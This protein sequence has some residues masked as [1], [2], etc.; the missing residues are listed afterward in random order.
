MRISRSLRLATSVA[1]SAVVIT[2]VGAALTTAPAFAAPRPRV[3]QPVI[4]LTPA[5]SPTTSQTMLATWPTVSGASYTCQLDRAKPAPCNSGTWSST[6]VQ[7]VLADGTHTLTVKATKSGNRPSTA[8]KTWVVDTTKPVPPTL[9]GVTSPTSTTSVHVSWSDLDANGIAGYL[10]ELNGTNLSAATICGNGSAS[11]G[12]GGP[13]GSWQLPIGSAQSGWNTVYVWATDTAGNTSVT[14]TPNS[15]ATGPAAGVT[16]GT[17][18]WKVDNSAP[19][20]PSF[21]QAPPANWNS[22]T[23]HFVWQDSDFDGTNTVSVTNFVCALDGP[24]YTPCNNAGTDVTVTA[25][26]SHS[27]SV[28]GRDD[29]GNVGP[30]ATWNW[31]VDTVAPPTPFINSVPPATSDLSTPS[32][33]FGDDEASVSFRCGFDSADVSTY[34]SCAS[35]FDSSSKFA[36]LNDGPHTFYVVA[37]DAAGNDSAAKTY[38]WTIDTSATT[39]VAVSAPSFTGAPAYWSND[40]NPAFTWVDN[41][42][43]P[44]QDQCKLDSGTWHNCTSGDSFAV[45]T[46]TLHTLSVRSVDA[47]ASATSDA[48]SWS[49]NYDNT[50]P[51]ASLTKTPATISNNP[52]PE[53]DFTSETGARFTCT[54]DTD[55]SSICGSPAIYNGV[56]DGPHTFA[57][58]AADAAGNTSTATYHWS[59][60]TS[61]PPAPTLVAPPAYTN[62]PP[63]SVSWTDSDSSVLPSSTCKLNGA[64]YTPCDA[65]GTVVTTSAD[66]SYTF[67]VTVS[68][69][70]HSSARSVT[71]TQDTQKPD[72]SGI[73]HVPADGSYSS[74]ASVTPDVSGVTDDNLDTVTCSLDGGAPAACGTIS[75]GDGSRTLDIVATDL[76][77]N[78][79][80]YTRTWTVDTVAPVVGVDVSG[81]VS[82]TGYNNTGNVSPAV[83]FDETNPDLVNF[84]PNGY[85][86]S[87]DDG[88]STVA[89]D[90]GPYTNLP[91]GHYTLTVTATD[92]AGLSAGPATANWTVDTTAPATPS[93]TSTDVENGGTINSAPTI[94]VDD[95]SNDVSSYSCTLSSV[96][97]TTTT[98]SVAAGAVEFSGSGL[99]DDSYTVSVT[100]TDAATNVSDTA[101]T[102]SFVIDSNAPA[103]PSVNGTSGVVKSTS[104]AFTLTDDD[105]TATFVCELDAETTFTPCD[106]N[107]S[108]HNLSEGDHTLSVKAV[109]SA[110]NM[111]PTQTVT[112]TVDTTAPQLVV[113]GVPTTLT[114]ATSVTPS[115]TQTGEAHPG[116]LVCGLD[117]AP[118]GC[119]SRFTVGDGSH[120][121]TA[122]TT[123]LAGNAAAQVTRSW[124]VDATAPSAKMTRM[125]SLTGR[126]TATW[127]EPVSGLDT[128]KVT[129]VD[130]NGGAV[131]PTAVS[132]G[133][134]DCS[135]TITSMS[136]APT[137][138]LLP[139]EHYT[140]KIGA[141]AAKD[142]ANNASL[143]SVKSFRALRTLQENTIP[144][145]SG[146][147]R[148]KT[149]AAYGKSYVREH[150]KG[151][152]ANWTFRGSRVTWWTVTGP[153][154]G[155]AAVFIDGHRLKTVN[156]YATATHYRVARTLRH[157]G[158]GTHRLTIRVMG[159]KGAKAGKGTFVA[160]DGFTVGTKRT[161][162]PKLATAWRR[163]AGTRY[164]GSH[165]TTANLAGQTV[166]LRF[167]GTSITWTTVRNRTQGKAR[168]YVDGV[169]KAT[170]DNYSSTARYKVRRVV[171]GLTDAVHTVKI[172][173]L[174][175]HRKASHGN[176]ITVDRLVVG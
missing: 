30:V 126:S 104:A 121:F 37:E 71:W 33:G 72:V 41:E 35:P 89:S 8:S 102:Y 128:S 45:S 118:V 137:K 16:P 165:A 93:L 156:T 80:T 163:V 40:A 1:A 143:V 10:C 5:T 59:I 65:A 51:V 82:S 141:G 116:A 154:Q 7:P 57:V 136:V 95:T 87:L 99:A 91:D 112:W 9:G 108:L 3:T 98:C 2:T 107:L 22:R 70:G 146:W 140:L 11:G 159:L 86:C 49:W 43:D 174:G 96:A 85:A 55:P 36:P 139:G 88:S 63:V 13:S 100:A 145:R 110:H 158:K 46:E 131:V 54:L 124:T 138:R 52:S 76:A 19:A 133:S 32:F 127:T 148:V 119:N 176:T 103:K 6:S 60:D 24:P 120:T 157:L 64:D 113:S 17:V 28:Q 161:A 117:G 56:G 144:V 147:Q 175:K 109:D 14:G 47:T 106:A 111:S 77:G 27:F 44:V 92:L 97:N 166:S 155:K 21:T 132:C 164:F 68:K 114:N 171:T 94:H 50:A 42:G 12:S 101:A 169:L 31:T 172:V 160:V 122:D 170:V 20:T 58:T 115:V 152:T 151:A 78:S 29:V 142:V 162:S 74:S 150:V 73:T 53:F 167:R 135:G 125:R 38:T 34:V 61:A 67:L 69:N 129:L 23:A 134:S 105:A 25:D 149:R 18:T 62:S 83:S 123:D 79:A 173:V 4:T 84:A 39:P 75:L 15:D 130:D 48:V 26:G 66:G 153:R 90:C 168:I 81:D